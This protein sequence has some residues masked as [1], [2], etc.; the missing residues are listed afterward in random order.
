MY[1]C[2]QSEG[3]QLGHALWTAKQSQSGFS[4]SFFWPSP[5][6]PA[7]VN[8]TLKKNKGKKQKK[9]KAKPSS[10]QGTTDKVASKQDSS[11]PKVAVTPIAAHQSIQPSNDPKDMSPKPEEPINLLACDAV[12]FETKDDVPGVKY[13]MANGSEGW[14]PVTRRRRRKSRTKLRKPIN[15]PDIDTTDSESSSSDLDMSCSRQIDYTIRDGVP[16]LTVYRRNPNPK[17]SP[18]APSPV[19]SRTRT[20]RKL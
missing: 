14:T 12:E 9:A 18:I 7:T 20:K 17:W 11:A 5:S 8:K 13:K 6:E 4:V 19:A 16:G 10:V 1:H 15:Y 3:L 2:L